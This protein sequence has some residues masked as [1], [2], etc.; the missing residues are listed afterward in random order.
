MYLVAVYMQYL[1]V[2][3]FMTYLDSYYIL[4]LYLT[5]LYL[6]N[7]ILIRNTYFII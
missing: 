3:I 2:H 7:N 6:Q 1:L 5:Y 4:H